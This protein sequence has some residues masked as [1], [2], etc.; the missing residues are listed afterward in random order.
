MEI[1]E[2][3]LEIVCLQE[4]FEYI[5]NDLIGVCLDTDAR[6]DSYYMLFHDANILEVVGYLRIRRDWDRI[7]ILEY[8]IFQKFRGRGFGKLFAKKILESRQFLTELYIKDWNVARCAFW[9]YI[10]PKF[11]FTFFGKH[12]GY[13]TPY[14]T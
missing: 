9:W 11:F 6:L 13:T 12:L 5:R 3:N 2:G 1:L 4:C 8:E 14:C 10:A 7:S